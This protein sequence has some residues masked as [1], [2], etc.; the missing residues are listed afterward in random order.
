MGENVNVRCTSSV[1]SWENRFELNNSVHISLLQTSEESVIQVGRV[2][3]VSVSRCCDAGVDACAIAVPSINVDCW[4]W[5]TSGGVDELDVEE[6]RD[7]GLVFGHVGAD[8]FAVD[9]VGSLG[10]FWLED[11]AGVGGEEV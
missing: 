8:E 9:V 2:V 1:M 7:A 3:L 6:E 11:T 5:L 4:D 10:D